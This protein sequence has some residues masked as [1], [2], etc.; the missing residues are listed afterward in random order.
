MTDHMKPTDVPYD[1]RLREGYDK[2]A[3]QYDALRYES[4]EGRFFS[5]LELTILKSWM[6]LGRGRRILDMPAGTGRL[7]IE[8]SHSGATVIGADISRNMLAE[9][10]AKARNNHATHAHF[11]Q[12][13]GIQ[14]PFADDTFDAVACFK[15][16]HLVP[17]DR[18]PLFIRELAR[19]LKPGCPLIVEFNSPFYGGCLAAFRYYFRKKIPGG[20]RTKCL[21]PDQVAALFRGLQVTRRCG[22]KLPGAGAVAAVFGARV[23]QAVNLWFGRLPGLRYF[24]YAIIIEARKPVA[25]EVRA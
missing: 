12:G 15:F 21:F 14:L 9:A 22:V 18:K 17:N 7:S 11:V 8:L 1:R 23:T 5:N 25:P 10:D 4:S 19:V 3:A 2:E 16:F 24:A 20:M 13:S 6:P